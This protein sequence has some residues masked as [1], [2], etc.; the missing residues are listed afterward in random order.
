[1]FIKIILKVKK[2]QVKISW[3][4]FTQQPFCYS[5]TMQLVA[6]EAKID[7]GQQLF[8]R[9]VHSSYTPFSL[10]LKMA[11]NMA[12]PLGRTLFGKFLNVKRCH[13][14]FFCKFKM[15]HIFC[16]YCYFFLPGNSC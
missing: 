16:N 12:F 9:C 10:E 2:A 7:T 8:S 13:V 1:M 3:Q 6:M 15:K 11:A 5:P 14:L 4:F